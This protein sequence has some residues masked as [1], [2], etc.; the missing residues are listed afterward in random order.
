MQV[1]TESCPDNWNVPVQWLVSQVWA[2]QLA[3]T[4]AHVTTWPEQTYSLDSFANILSVPHSERHVIVL[5]FEKLHQ[6]KNIHTNPS[7]AT[8]L[9]RFQDMTS[10][11]TSSVSQGYTPHLYSVFMMTAT[12]AEHCGKFTSLSGAAAPHMKDH[13]LSLHNIPSYS[14][15][16]GHP[17]AGGK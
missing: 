16:V 14:L 5:V 6:L 12:N 1:Y 4:L 10:W 15:S 7:K 8:D 2:L 13:L 17:T 11:P 9:H 3:H